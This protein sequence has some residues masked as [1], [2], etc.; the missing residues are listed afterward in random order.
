MN[1][2]FLATGIRTGLLALVVALLYLVDLIG[3]KFETPSP[4]SVV[5]S[6]VL[7]VLQAAVLSYVIVHSSWHGWKLI[8]AM[9]GIY[10]GI[11]VFQTQIESVVFLQYLTDVIPADQM[12]RLIANGTIT[13]ALVAPLAVW[14]HGKFAPP[15]AAAAPLV[16]LQLTVIGWVWRFV[17]LGVVYMI[18]Y[19]LFGALVFKPL[20]GAAF[21]EYYGNLQL[22]DWILPFQVL[23]GMIWVLITVPVVR[24]MRGSNL[25]VGLSVSV[26]L[27]VLISSLVLVPNEFMPPAIRSAHFVE[28]F[29]S[30]F[31][32][33][34]ID[35]WILTWQRA[36]TTSQRELRGAS[37]PV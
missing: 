28:L 9:F 21:D 7:G 24:M 33:G 35:V 32:F 37:R 22:P 23:R 19:I 30:M 16:R 1:N 13:A 34:W 17:A 15:A 4:E 31:V 27:A 36:Q 26:L 3:L 5:W 18:I 10:W 8:A 20:A 29:T 2:R 11:T 12:P 6:L 25:Q 14:I